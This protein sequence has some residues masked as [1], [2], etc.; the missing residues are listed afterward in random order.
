M[1]DSKILD[2]LPPYWR[3]H[4]VMR[5]FANATGEPFDKWRTTIGSLPSYVDPLATPSSWVSGLM[6]LVGLPRLDWLTETQ[7][8]LLIAAA[9]ETWTWKGTERGI[10]SYL[11]AVTGVSAD[12]IRV[13]NTAFIAGISKA[14]DICGPGVLG[15]TWE[16]EVPATAGFTETQIRNILE[17]V[18]SS[19]ETYTVTFV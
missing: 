2:L 5:D 3:K 11:R 10:E 1:A 7:R 17:P 4:E 8:R 18:A 6:R 14:D 16:V 15:W 13:A 19:L 12:V 9:F